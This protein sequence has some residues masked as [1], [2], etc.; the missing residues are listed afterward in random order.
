MWL[1]ECVLPITWTARRTEKISWVECELL[2]YNKEVL[3]LTFE[4][5]RGQRRRLAVLLTISEFLHASG[6]AGIKIAVACCFWIHSADSWCR[7]C[8]LLTRSQ[9]WGIV[10]SAAAWAGSSHPKMFFINHYVNVGGGGGSICFYIGLC[11]SWKGQFA[12]KSSNLSPAVIVRICLPD[13]WCMNTEAKRNNN[14]ICN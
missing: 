14:E 9:D 2:P 1:L 5:K 7:F 12:A 6:D 3:S 8:M 11:G 4:R 10:S 13:K